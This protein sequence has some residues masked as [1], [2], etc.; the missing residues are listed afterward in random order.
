MI[1]E[2]SPSFIALVLASGMV[3][4]MIAILNYL[5]NRNLL[6][7]P[8][9]RKKFPD[10]TIFKYN[11]ITIAMYL[12]AQILALIKIIR[13]TDSFDSII[14]HIFLIGDAAIITFFFWM[15]HYSVRE[16]IP[17]P[18]MAVVEEQ[19]NV[20]QDIKENLEQ[21]KSKGCNT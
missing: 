16:E 21:I 13:D 3:G 10:F 2:G 12:A 17:S 20:L 11:L 19:L 5:Q 15:Y 9:F 7:C 4:I 18:S 8:I 14:I 1:P 6:K